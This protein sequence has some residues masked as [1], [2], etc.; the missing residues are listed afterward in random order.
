MPPASSKAD[1]PS[2]EGRLL[3]L[4]TAVLYALFTLLPNSNSLMVAWPTVFIW[5]IAL[6]APLLWLLWQIGQRRQI[7]G[8]GLGW[9][10]LVGFAL[11][12][13]LVSTWGAEFPQQ[14]RWF[15]W[16]VLGY[17]SALYALN[18]WL[19]TPARRQ[20][21]LVFQG[22]LSFAF[23]LLSLALWFSQTLLPHLNL[24]QQFQ[25]LGVQQ[26]FS[27]GTLE[28]RNWAPIGHQNYVAG[29]LLLALPLL[30][31]LG[32]TE[33]GKKRWFWFSGVG[34]GLLDLYTTSSRGG[35]L[36]LAVLCLLGLLG[37]SRWGQLGWRWLLG[38]V[39][40]TSGLLL[41]IL[42]SNDRFQAIVR[43][44]FQ[45]Q[46][47]ELSYRLLNMEV[48]WRMGSEHLW[49]GVGLGGV[50]LLYQRY[51]PIW[52]GRESELIH[53]L[54]STPAQLFAEMGL[55]GLV[56]GIAAM[57]VL[58][59]C[60]GRWWQK[61]NKPPAEIIWVWSLSSGLWAYVV[62]SLTDYQL[63]NLGISGFLV[64]VSAILL[65]YWRSSPQEAKIHPLA[66][67]LFY[68]GLGLVLAV[69][70]WLFPIHR[71]WQLS[72]LGFQALAAQKIPAFEQYL[73]QAQALAPWEA[74]YPNQL[75]WNLGNLALTTENSQEQQGL[76]QRAIT[77]L[78]KAAQVSPYQEF[79]H[80]NLGWLQLGQDPRAA[81]RSFAQALALV[82][83][84]R[85]LFYGLGLSLL[86]QQQPELALQAFRLECLR[87]PIF[88]TSPLW[89]TPL[90]ITLYPP[91]LAQVRQ[92]L[93]RLLEKTSPAPELQPL[94]HQIRGGLAWWMGDYP[95]AQSDLSQYGTTTGQVLLAIAQNQT[96]PPQVLAA[97]PSVTR[98]A[99]QA[100]Q[101]PA[102][103]PQ[104]LQ[105]AWI[106]ATQTLF[107]DPL[108]Q[109]LLASLA[110]TP[111]LPQWLRQGAPVL[112]YRRQRLGYGI[113]SRHI[114]GPNPEDFFRVVDN[115]PM[116]L[117][118]A[119]LLPSPV[120]APALDQALQ[121]QRQQLLQQ[122]EK[123]VGAS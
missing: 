8:L 61:P 68:G 42:A 16:S 2:N 121:P 23:I 26:R 69:G 24:L 67:P 28:L 123:Q 39:I 101:D 13:L 71:A 38:I 52:A 91:L 44:L 86:L 80:N 98:T 72:N 82:P 73:T 58:L 63:D 22:Y 10:Y 43:S 45:G 93:D 11:L 47:G 60:L 27:F 117:W 83:A 85:G 89:R 78:E 102:Q 12:G 107:P 7:Q 112:Q 97:L 50:P 113:V 51:R 25:A 5:Q 95:Q 37:L 116:T 35:L 74:Y 6:L 109:Q 108:E 59:Y 54:H 64:M 75:G 9:D 62:M 40:T 100:W 96:P 17:L 1:W 41:L 87:D 115:L 122:V 4:L 20:G 48:G 33:L 119:D 49:T 103:R 66:L 118:F 21:L 19:Q 14:A 84:K 31:A 76:Q 29:Y 99:L 46:G 55:W 15:A 88:I 111:N 110:Q 94:L 36:G 79:T 70:I 57:V 53:Q 3:G 92:D 65:S 32:L 90:L 105:Q 30:L 81:S 77:A 18:T 56:L 104:R 34:L 120:L 106:E 114:D